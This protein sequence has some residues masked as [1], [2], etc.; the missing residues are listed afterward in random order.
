MTLKSVDW[1]EEKMPIR[2]N[3]LVNHPQTCP[4]F[5]ART[6]NATQCSHT[7]ATI[8]QTTQHLDM[9]FFAVIQCK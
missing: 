5:I 3:V 1:I 4:P 6:I 9:P 7:E 2:V 8:T